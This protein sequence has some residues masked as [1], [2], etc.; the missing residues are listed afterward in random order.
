M[1]TTTRPLAEV[2]AEALRLLYRELGAVDA[3]R[4][5]RQYS[6][7]LGNYTAEREQLFGE[8]SLD[9]IVAAIEARRN[10]SESET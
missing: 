1:T 4:F 7:G 10:E 8:L 9:E 5:L 6:S 2:N 3:A